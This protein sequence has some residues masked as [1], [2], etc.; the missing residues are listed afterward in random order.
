MRDDIGLLGILNLNHVVQNAKR[1]RSYKHRHVPSSNFAQPR[2]D[3]CFESI[4]ADL[5]LTLKRH[6]DTKVSEHHWYCRLQGR[7]RALLSQPEVCN[8]RAVESWGTIFDCLRSLESAEEV[9]RLSHIYYRRLI[10]LVE[11]HFLPQDQVT[12]REALKTMMLFRYLDVPYQG[13]DLEYMTTTGMLL[14]KLHL[15]CRGQGLMAWQ[16]DDSVVFTIEVDREQFAAWTVKRMHYFQDSNTRDKL[17]SDALWS[18]VFATAENETLDRRRGRLSS[19]QVFFVLGGDTPS[20]AAVSI[21]LPDAE[22]RSMLVFESPWSQDRGRRVQRVLFDLPQSFPKSRILVWEPGSL[23]PEARVFLQDYL[24]T[25]M[26]LRYAMTQKH[27]GVPQDWLIRALRRRYLKAVPEVLHVLTGCFQQGQVV[28][29]AAT[30]NPV[31]DDED[32]MATLSLVADF[33]L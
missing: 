14:V 3:I 30:L 6:L 29:D 7:L 15:L 23:D 8:C 9:T 33:A 20:R 21:Y 5:D 18:I 1:K 26:A 16:E 17:L 13:Y 32:L 22:V 4:P 10:P 27:H 11:Q 25:G 28:S 19:G 24:A 2:N 31:P 12:L